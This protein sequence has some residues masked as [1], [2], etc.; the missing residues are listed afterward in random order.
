MQI[1]N[2]LVCLTTQ[3]V[4][5]DIQNPA[6]LESSSQNG[7]EQPE[8]KLQVLQQL[9]KTNKEA[10]ILWDISNKYNIL[11]AE[12]LN[13]T[14]LSEL[15][16]DSKLIPFYVI[17]V[18]LQQNEELMSNYIIRRYHYF[19]SEGSLNTEDLYK[20]KTEILNDQ[21]IYLSILEDLIKDL[22]FDDG[23][24]KLCVSDSLCGCIPVNRIQYYRMNFN[25]L[26]ENRQ[27]LSDFLMFKNYIEPIFRAILV[28]IGMVLNCTLILIFIKE[29]SIRNESNM[30]ILN[31]A[32]CNVIALIAYIPTN[33]IDQYEKTLGGRGFTAVELLTVSLNALT[34]LFLNIQRYFEVSRV[35][36]TDG[37]SCIS[38]PIFRSLTYLIVLWSW[39]ILISIFCGLVDTRAAIFLEILIYFLFYAF[40]LSLVLSIFNSLTARKLHRA[41]KDG[42]ASTEFQH[43]IGSGVVLSLT[44][45]Y[46]SIHI[47]F[48]I[49]KIFEL[50][51]SDFFLDIYAPG[52]Y[53]LIIFFI[54]IIFFLYPCVSIV[55]LYK[56]SSNYRNF[57]Q[58]YLFQCWYNPGESK[59]VT[60]SSVRNNDPE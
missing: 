17:S 47:P 49:Y 59:Y 35:L 39:S 34:V 14:C 15:Q 28:I 18:T 13:M 46:Y 19:G 2:L 56:A 48:F 44:V 58:K 22:P 3:P 8:Q 32:I 33:Y 20:N 45:L 38:S 52:T 7:E 21:Q 55:V 54:H 51:L 24:E 1:L 50:I 6:V 5:S 10:N 11:K 27:G 4:T 29:K 31:L 41:A 60:M 16:K 43:I 53:R 36:N 40:A 26:K 25:L 12:E 42:K 30:L 23:N 9:V 37:K 57:F